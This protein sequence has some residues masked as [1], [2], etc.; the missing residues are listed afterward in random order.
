[1]SDDNSTNTEEAS[2]DEAGVV[3]SL[4]QDEIDNLLGFDAPKSDTTKTNGIKAMLDKALESYER[5]P[6]LEVV[7]DRFVRILSA[8]LRNF[9][10]DTVDVDIKSISSLRYGSYVDSVPMPALLMV[11][12]AIE[13]ENFGLMFTDG[14]LIYSLVDIL[15]G[16]RK[17]V[18]PQKIEGRPYTSI[19]QDI[20]KQLSEIVLADLSEAF[21]PLSPTT[22]VFER[23]ET[24]PRFATIARPGDAAIL[25][26]LK[27]EMEE[28]SGKLDI[29]FP[30]A[31][32]EP[33]RLLLLQVLMGERFGKDS[34][35]E[36]MLQQEVANVEVVL[37]A[38]LKP[39]Q[40]LM[41]DIIKLKVGSTIVMDDILDDD[42]ILHCCENNMFSGK[43]GKIGDKIGVEITKILNNKILTEEN[44]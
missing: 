33:I 39:K 38:T 41:S 4:N 12:K 20:A 3:K 11:F 21:D 24:N 1:M 7:F 31:T 5:L 26:Q 9:T 40:A 16:G 30:Y 29:L 25:L 27:V 6:M 35:W 2:W 36:H 22:L 42:I 17:V 19:E 44:K 34:Q 28:R 14:A 37:E 8:S 10:S 18:R 23:I 43:V 32:L 13:W 15:F